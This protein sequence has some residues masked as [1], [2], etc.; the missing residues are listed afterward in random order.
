M[1]FLSF[2]FQ[3]NFYAAIETSAF[4]LPEK[5]ENLNTQIFIKEIE[6][7]NQ[8]LPTKK[9]PSFD[10]FSCT[11]VQ[12]FNEELIPILH[13]LFQRIDKKEIFPNSFSEANITCQS[14]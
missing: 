11:F 8:N 7:T 12:I 10:V 5:L 13:K 9:T 3:Y 4:Q 14:T 6:S 1:L 2:N